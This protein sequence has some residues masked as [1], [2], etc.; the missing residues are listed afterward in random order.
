MSYDIELLDPVTRKCLEMPDK[1]QMQGA[2][3]AVGGTTSME[4]NITY[5]YSTLLYRVLDG[6]IRSI[7]GLSGLE[8]IP[9]LE[10]AIGK[11]GNKVDEDYWIATEGNI[12]RALNSLLTFAKA[13]PDG[14]W[15]GD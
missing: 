4:F 2:T 8:S 13:R 3:Y 5:N 1:H 14:I 10:E 12:K 7:Y 15:D 6:G 9:L 11:L